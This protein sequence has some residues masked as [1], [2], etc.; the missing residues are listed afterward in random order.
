MVSFRGVP[1]ME[2]LAQEAPRPEIIKIMD[3]PVWIVMENLAQEAPRP[4]IIQIIDKPIG[5]HEG[6]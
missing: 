5:K 3:T 1:R 4:E 6:F 2:N